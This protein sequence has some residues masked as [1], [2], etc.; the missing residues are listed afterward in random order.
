MVCEG[1]LRSTKEA[2]RM[3]AV[4]PPPSIREAWGGPAVGV[5]VLGQGWGLLPRHFPQSLPLRRQGR[6]GMSLLRPEPAGGH[7]RAWRSGGGEQQKT[8]SP[9][10]QQGRRMWVF[11]WGGMYIAWL[12]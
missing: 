5:A 9:H 11:E 10:P 12:L 3:G 8:W 6:G 4:S 2:S 7:V 1:P